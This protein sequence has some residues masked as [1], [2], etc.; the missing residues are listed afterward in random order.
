MISFFRLV[1]RV[2]TVT[3]PVPVLRAERELLV[4]LVA[5]AER[6]R[7]VAVAVLSASRAT[8]KVSLPSL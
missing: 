2:V 4:E 7:R 8:H 1:A 6:Q 5:S 3:R